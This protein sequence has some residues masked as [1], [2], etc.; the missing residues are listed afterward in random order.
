MRFTFDP[1]AAI[2]ATPSRAIKSRQ[3]PVN[4]MPRVRRS[5]SAHVVNQTDS[6]KQK[7]AKVFDSPRGSEGD[8]SPKSR[9][10]NGFGFVIAATLDASIVH[11]FFLKRNREKY[12]LQ[13]KKNRANF[14]A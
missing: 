3:N 14:A 1:F 7:T 2:G 4:R 5:L 9:S 12:A 10:L 8:F 13:N 11:A 6:G